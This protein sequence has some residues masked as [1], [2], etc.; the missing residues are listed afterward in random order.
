MHYW[1]KS[2]GNF[3]EKS[4]IFLIGQSGEASRWRGYYQR[5]LPRLVVE[6]PRICYKLERRGKH[7]TRDWQKS[8]Y[9]D[10]D[11]DNNNDDLR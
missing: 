2:H 7:E 5:G 1:F 6:Q 3:A 4:D 11:D 10:C 8:K 9:E